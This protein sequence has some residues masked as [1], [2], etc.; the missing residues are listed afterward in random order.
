MP[1]SKRQLLNL[2][3]GGWRLVATRPEQPQCGQWVLLPAGHV[4]R[5]HEVTRRQMQRGVRVVVGQGEPVFYPLNV[6]APLANSEK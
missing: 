1:R 6:I 3:V 5:V 4:G 2:R